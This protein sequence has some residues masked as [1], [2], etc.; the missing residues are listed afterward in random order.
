MARHQLP[1]HGSNLLVLGI[2]FK[3]NCPDIRNSRV[4]D[5][6]TEL[7]SYGASVEVYDPHADAQEVKHEY[8]LTLINRPDKQYHG[9]VLAVSH[10]E[11][12]TLNWDALLAPRAVVYDVKGFL[13]RSI[14]TERL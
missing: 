8:G 9:V 13:D 3:E 4:I 10:D 5:I 11:F 2:T 14:V 7:Q 6:I 12:R 1:I